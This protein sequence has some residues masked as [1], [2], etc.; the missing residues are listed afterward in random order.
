[1]VIQMRVVVSKVRG[2]RRVLPL[3]ATATLAN[4]HTATA[5]GRVQGV[6]LDQA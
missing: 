2:L 5:V 4:R 1:M 6:V 3:A